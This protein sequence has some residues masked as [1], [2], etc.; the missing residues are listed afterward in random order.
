M[1]SQRCPETDSVLWLQLQLQPAF[2]AKTGGDT[3]QDLNKSKL[4]MV[5]AAAGDVLV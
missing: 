5:V 4:L 2:R 1:H 3:W